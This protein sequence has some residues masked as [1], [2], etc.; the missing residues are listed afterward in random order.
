MKRYWMDDNGQ[1]VCD[2]HAG[3]YLR[4]AIEARPKARTHHTPLGMWEQ[5]TDEDVSEFTAMLAE[6]GIARTHVCETCDWRAR[7]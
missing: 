6:H 5:M 4:S 2:E 3:S 1:T 7:A